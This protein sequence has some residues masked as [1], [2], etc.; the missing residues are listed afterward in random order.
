MQQRCDSGAFHPHQR[1]Q[2]FGPPPARQ[3]DY[4]Y[5]LHIVRSMKSTGKG[6]CILPHGLLFR[7]NAVSA[8]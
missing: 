1:F 6:A 7:G 2:L 4:A 3:G 5:L 8:D